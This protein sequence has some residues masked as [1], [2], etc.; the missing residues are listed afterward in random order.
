M[1]QA[2]STVRALSTRTYPVIE[3]FGSTI[4][5]E[6]YLAG[7]P[8]HFVRFGGCDY[9]CTWCDSMYAVEPAL[10]REHAE[11]L[12]A[13]QIA[14]RLHALPGEPRWLTLSGGN[15]AL[16]RF[17]PDEF[18]LF[19]RPWLV[20]VETQGSIWR[21]WLGLVDHL[22]VSPKPPSSG[23]VNERHMRALAA[24]M[25]RAKKLGKEAR[26]IK[27]VVFDDLDYRWAANLFAAYPDWHHYLS[28][29]TDPTGIWDSP[30]VRRRI[31]DDEARRQI[32]ESYA[33]LAERV[34]ND[35]MMASVRV[36]PQLHVIAWGHARGV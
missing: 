8:T 16:M 6:G 28:V 20:S 7:L 14:E 10:V 2:E 34:A 26:S 17:S 1:A 18:D 36:F 21:D 23:M 25:L 15:P 11:P 30:D 27:I 5:G 3:I 35:P 4:Q 24:F 13:M 32:G 9:R 22:T 33:R 19:F 29:G 31:S 12:T